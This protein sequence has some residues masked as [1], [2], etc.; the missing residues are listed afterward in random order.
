VNG[1]GHGGGIALSRFL[2]P[3]ALGLGAVGLVLI[4][5]MTWLGLWQ[6]SVY[7]NHQHAEAQAALAEPEVPLDSLIGPDD[8]F[9]SDG[10][11]RPV[12]VTGTYLAGDQIYIRHLPG[13]PDQYAVAT[14]LLTA[15]GS[16]IMIVRGSSETPS[17]AVPTGRVTVSGIL[18]PATAISRPP[19]AAGI[20]DGLS[21]SSLVDAVE[22]DLY[23]GYVLLRSSNP[24]QSPPLAS[25][26]P[27]LPDPSRWAGL[28]NL[29]YACQWW[30]FAMFVVFMWWRMTGDLAHEHPREA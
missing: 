28:R 8:A 15:S 6:F 7:D 25:V 29:L 12:Q 24:E 5:L 18:E 11:S 23:S 22:P 21:I 20:T 2:N 1:F 9:P 19:N 14:P 3:R 17:A 27:Q 4:A 13:S 26:A 16:A 30:V 10:V